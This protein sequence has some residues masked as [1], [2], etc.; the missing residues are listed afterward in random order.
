[1]RHF[2]RALLV[3]ALG[4]AGCGPH[5][6]RAELERESFAVVVINHHWLDV[7]VYLVHDGQRTRVG[8]VT[9]TTTEQFALSTQLLGSSREIALIGEAV[10]SKE[11]IRTELLAV[12]AGQYV[13]WTL[14]NALRRSSVAVY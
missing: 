10:G 9:A 3:L 1:M 5:R 2:R 7:T 8:T 6:A 11:M 13:E 12:Q 4:V 14:E